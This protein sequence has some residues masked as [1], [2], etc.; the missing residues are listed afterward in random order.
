MV[1]L[2]GI[3]KGDIVS[4]DAPQ[5]SKEGSLG[6][7]STGSSQPRRA[8]LGNK[9]DVPHSESLNDLMGGHETYSDGFSHERKTISRVSSK[10]EMMQEH[11]M[12]PDNKSKAEAISRKLALEGNTLNSG[13]PWRPPS[14]LEQLNIVDWRDASGDFS[15]RDADM[16]SNASKDSPF[17]LLG[18]AMPHLRPKARPPPGFAV[19]KPNEFT[20]TFSWPNISSF[21]NMH[22]SLNELN[23]IRNDSS[24]KLGSTT[25]AENR[26]LESLMSANMGASS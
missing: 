17:L 22:S 13:T 24:S 11:I 9:E 2:K 4:S 6:Q 26:F 5:I 8:Q 14:L 15:L 10:L 12:Y 16:L 21:G 23:I 3:D 18:D 7:N 19:M 25:E 1:V 20:D